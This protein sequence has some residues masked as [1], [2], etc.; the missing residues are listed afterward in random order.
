[1]Q[2]I[3]RDLTIIKQKRL[4]QKTTL[5]VKHNHGAE[6]N[7]RKQARRQTGSRRWRISNARTK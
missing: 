4:S 5:K 2:G 3:Q 6:L 1:M 7:G